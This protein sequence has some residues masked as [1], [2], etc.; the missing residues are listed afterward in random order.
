MEH[1]GI[2]PL[3]RGWPPTSPLQGFCGFTELGVP[4]GFIVRLASQ[5]KSRLQVDA[6]LSE[7]SFGFS[8]RE[9]VKSVEYP[10]LSMRVLSLKEMEKGAFLPPIS[11]SSHFRLSALSQNV[12]LERDPI[13]FMKVGRPQNVYEHIIV[14]M[15]MNAIMAY[16]DFHGAG[17]MGSCKEILLH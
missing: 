2:F 6:C 8:R 5:H 16:G 13:V 3:K 7:L 9:R 10:W 15:Q 12:T 1:C 4:D 14:P 11:R 17:F